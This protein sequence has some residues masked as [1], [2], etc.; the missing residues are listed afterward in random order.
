MALNRR[1]AFV[2]GIKFPP[3]KCIR[4]RK[5]VAS[6][7]YHNVDG[8]YLVHVRTESLA[9]LSLQCISLHCSLYKAFWHCDAEPCETQ[10][11]WLPGSVETSYGT[12]SFTA[13]RIHIVACRHETA[14][15]REPART[16]PEGRTNRQALRRARPLARRALMTARPPRVRI[17]ARNPWVRLRLTSLGWN[18]LFMMLYNS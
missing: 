16:A 12:S 18:V 3:Q 8:R 6:D 4:R 7:S 14:R 5:G 10:S 9:N 17:R 15:A 1:H 2:Q 11:V 13:Q